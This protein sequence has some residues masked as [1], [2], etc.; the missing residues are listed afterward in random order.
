MGRRPYIAAQAGVVLVLAIAGLAPLAA[1]L[2]HG[3]HGYAA[4]E[5]IEGGAAVSGRVNQQITVSDISIGGTGD[6]TVPVKLTVNSGSLWLGTTDGLTFTGPATGSTL[7]FS[8]ARSDVNAA[9]ATLHYVST[10][11]GNDTL[12]VALAAPDQIYNEDNGHVYQYIGDQV[13]WQDAYDAAAAATYDGVPGYLATI[14]SQ[15]ENDF[16]Q[17]K[18][19]GDGWLGAS[20]SDDYGGEGVWEWAAGPEAGTNFYNGQNGEID[21]TT[22]DGQYANWH[23][24]EPNQSGDED[25]LETYI[26][27]GDWNDWSCDNTTGYVIEFGTDGDLPSAIPSKDVSI[28]TTTAVFTGGNGDPE[29]PYQITDCERLQDMNQDLSAN[30]VLTHDI[31]CTETAGWNGGQGF[32]PIGDNGSRFSGTLDGGGFAIDSLTEIRADEDPDTTYG[33]DPATNQQYVGLF[34]FTDS[35]GISDVHLTSAMIKGYQYVGGIVGYMLNSTLTDSSVNTN[36]TST[37][38]DCDDH[39]IWARYGEDGGGLVG[40]LDGGSISGSSTGGA[41]KGSGNIIGGL[42]GVVTDGAQLTDSTTSS[43]VNGG[44][45][46]GGAVGE[47][48]N[49]SL[50]DGV[51]A[52][53]DVLATQDDEVNKPGYT[54]GGLVGYSSNST[55]T[56]SRASG[57]VHAD[58]GNAGGLAGVIDSNTHLTDAYATGDVTSDGSTVGGLIG[59]AYYSTVA[60]VYASGSA[61]GSSD[62]GGLAGYAVVTAFNDA[63]AAGSVSGDSELGGV[64]GGSYDPPTL[65]QVYFDENST[66]QTECFGDGELDGCTAISQ[67]NYFTHKANAPFTQAGSEVWL[68]SVWEFDAEHLPVFGVTTADDDGITTTVENAAPNGGDAD[69]DGT[70]DSQQAGVASFVNPVTSKY[71][72]VAVSGG[73]SLS[74][75]SAQAAALDSDSGYTYPFGLVNFTATCGSNGFT[76]TVHE[77]FYDPSDGTFVLRKFIGSAY[78]TITDATV[79]RQTIGGRSVLVVSYD[80][81]DGGAL[82][83]DGTANGVIVDPA[84]PAAA[85]AAV[86]VPNT[87]LLPQSPLGAMLALFVGLGLATLAGVL[88]VKKRAI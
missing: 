27:N 39:C 24:G 56:L 79:S 52:S 41:V 37:N 50:I 17:S 68:G 61:Q 4:G 66:G 26:E 84:G 59:A 65:T 48:Y 73:C 34:G 49:G 72:A 30:Y 57:D 23:D 29:T 62:V 85:V 76:A 88:L 10:S 60:R 14:T 45:S 25:C 5:T 86:G 83:A 80:V 31:D 15:A 67:A 75:V 33:T 35:A 19:S 74:D 18:L 69:G 7:T 70:A 38:G 71:A 6:G 43:P 55:I 32:L 40:Y 11:A 81:T 64:I 77:Y 78:Q 53:G 51:T 42:V 20:D 28:T 22:V 58:Y 8:G 3:R 12:E 16:I 54:A 47:V 87:G 1:D 63:F 46:I 82:D 2:W 36:I 21:G 13:T 44:R 9:L